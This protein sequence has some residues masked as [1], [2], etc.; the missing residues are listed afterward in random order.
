MGPLQAE[1]RVPFMMLQ[2]QLLYE[3]KPAAAWLRACFPSPLGQTAQ[4]WP[5]CRCLAMRWTSWS[6]LP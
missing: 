4:A 1:A 6:K 3:M 5:A 2:Q